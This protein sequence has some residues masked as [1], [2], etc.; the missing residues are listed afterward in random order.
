M[1]IT[2]LLETKNGTYTFEGNLSDEEVNT[3]ITV[4]IGYL[5]SV[6]AM[7]FVKEDGKITVESFDFDDDDSGEGSFE[8]TTA[9]H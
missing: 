7:P 1:Q 3:I 9:R 5:L 6:G 2:K 8:N 4:G